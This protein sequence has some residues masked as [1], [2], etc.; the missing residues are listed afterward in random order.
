MKKLTNI[1]RKKI[2][3]PK[4]VKESFDYLHEKNSNIELLRKHFKLNI[5]L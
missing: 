4:T 2:A 1:S 3:K 5:D